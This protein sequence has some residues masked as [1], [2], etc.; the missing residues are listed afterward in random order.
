MHT[1]RN[2]YKRTYYND[3]FYVLLAPGF[4]S[5]NRAPIFYFG[6]KDGA[7]IF[8]SAK[9]V[10][11][12]VMLPFSCF[13]LLLLFSLFVSWTVVWRYI[14]YPVRRTQYTAFYV[15]MHE[16]VPFFLLNSL[17]VLYIS[18]RVTRVGIYNVMRLNFII[19]FFT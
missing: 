3:I 19:R 10:Y 12:F 4:A 6:Y 13:L 11:T 18:D 5:I 2:I 9:R 1:F 14:H 8:L 16:E 15:Y 7:N 17:C